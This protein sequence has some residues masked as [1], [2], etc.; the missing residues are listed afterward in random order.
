MIFDPAGKRFIVFGGW[1]RLGVYTFALSPP[2]ASMA[3]ANVSPGPTW[4]G[5]V[6]RMPRK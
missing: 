1:G 2:A 6:G 5:G 4:D 3:P